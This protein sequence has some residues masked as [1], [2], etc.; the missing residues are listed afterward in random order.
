MFVHKHDDIHKKREQQ[1][2]RDNAKV[3]G[4]CNVNKIEI[5]K[6]HKKKHSENK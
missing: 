4:S 6:N 5:N 1:L 2:M 3:K